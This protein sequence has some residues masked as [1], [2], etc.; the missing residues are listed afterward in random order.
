MPEPLLPVAIV[1][2]SKADEDK[3]SQGL[4]RLVAEDPTLRLEHNP[5]THQLVL[6]CMGEAHARRAARP[7]AQ[8]L[9]RR[10][11]RRCR[12]GCR[13][14]RRSPARPTGHGRHVK[15]SGGHGQYAVCDIEVEPLPSGC[16]LR[17]RRQG[18]RR[19]GAAAVHPLGREGRARPDGARRRG[20]LPGRRPPGHA[21]R[22]QGALG[23]LLRHGLPDRRRAGA[24]RRR[25]KAA[26]VHLLEPVDEVSVLVAD[27]YVGAVMSD[28]SDPARPGAPAP[29]R[30]AA[31]RTLVKAEV[32]AAR[33]HPVR[34][35]PALARRTAP[36][37]SPARTSGTSRCRPSSPPSCR[38]TQR[39]ARTAHTS[40]AR[41]AGIAVQCRFDGQLSV[42]RSIG[43]RFVHASSSAGKP[44]RF[45]GNA[46]CGQLRLAD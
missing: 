13:C 6:W 7:A 18:R 14:A 31:G 26:T 5:E 25:A 43:P 17:V 3:L 4:R 27:E 46:G 42:A 45:R 38:P 28:L 22:R 19:R 36:A 12:C 9:R 39:T 20:R 2:K 35:R 33:D 32:P 41:R 24:A 44:R 21:D 15:Q 10:R 8:P 29:S 11:R 40:G 16:G 34:R 1:A 23:R 30:S 37:R